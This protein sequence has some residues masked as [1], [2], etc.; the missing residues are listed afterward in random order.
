MPQNMEDREDLPC[1]K[2]DV[3]SSESMSVMGTSGTTWEERFADMERKMVA[4]EKTVEDKDLE[5]AALK[6]QLEAFNDDNHS[7]ASDIAPGR[8][9]AD[10]T[11]KVNQKD[12]II[13]L[14]EKVDSVDNDDEEW[15]LVT[16]RKSRKRGDQ[17]PKNAPLSRSSQRPQNVPLNKSQQKRWLCP[18]FRKED[19]KGPRVLKSDFSPEVSEQKSPKPVKLE[20]FFP[21]GFLNEDEI[22]VGVHAVSITEDHERND[23]DEQNTKPTNVPVENLP[24]ATVDENLKNLK[25]ISSRLTIVELLQYPKVIASTG[26]VRIEGKKQIEITITKEPSE[27]STG[28]SSSMTPKE[29]T[30]ET[31]LKALSLGKKQTPILRYVPKVRRKE[32][33]SP[34]S[35]PLEFKDAELCL[36]KLK[37]NMQVLKETCA[38]PLVSLANNQVSKL[39]EGFVR[40]SKGAIEHGTFHQEGT[41]QSYGPNA[42]KLI[43]K[44]GVDLSKPTAVDELHTEKM[45]KKLQGITDAHQKLINETKG[46]SFSKVGL[47]REPPK[48]IRIYG[49]KKDHS[50]SIQHISVEIIN[51]VK[52]PPKFAFQNS[53]RVSVFNRLGDTSTSRV[54]VFAR[55]EV[56]L[57]NRSQIPRRK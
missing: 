11:G 3:V 5:I 42:Y 22:I 38:L 20:E 35:K 50:A 1:S 29:M 6:S 49:K 45:T 39:L 24:K 25:G 30:I 4:L 31:S 17:H 41:V 56:P 55:L 7:D 53:S 19:N 10:V 18:F 48:P 14:S 51:E 54:S 8:L 32:G 15:I 21:K 23:S 2:S 44:A 28:E 26:N 47:G 34:F 43:A 13:S 37:Q 52:I 57:P 12:S 9:G 46:R 36:E 40:P 27:P 33:Q 16:R